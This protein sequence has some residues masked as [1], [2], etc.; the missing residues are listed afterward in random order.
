MG[1]STDAPHGETFGVIEQRI[2][3]HLGPMLG[4]GLIRLDAKVH[5]GQGNVS[6]TKVFILFVGSFS[7]PAPYSAFA[8]A[9]VHTQG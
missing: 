4:K 5:R 8:N 1:P 7:T 2:A 9:C 3:S 6:A